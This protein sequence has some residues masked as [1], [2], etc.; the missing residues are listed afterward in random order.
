V[1]LGCLAS[2]QSAAAAAP[3]TTIATG[4][5]DLALTNDNTPTF[6]FS[7]DQAGVTFTCSVESSEVPTATYTC[8]SPFTAP[9]L[10]DGG[11]VVRIAAK[12][13]G[14]EVETP[15]AS[16]SFTVD[17]TPP[18]T[19]ITAGPADGETIDTD[20]PEFGWAASE[21][22]STFACTAD[23]IALTSCDLAFVTGA[24]AGRHSYSVA[25]TDAAGNTDPTPATRTF[26]ISFSG[27][28]PT[29]ARCQVDG[30]VVVGTN[31]ADTRV[32]TAGTDV[33]FGLA[34]N[35][36]LSAAGGRDCLA[37]QSGTGDDLLSGGAGND[38]LIGDAGRDELRGGAGN[39]SITGSAGLDV[40][41]GDAG[42]DR[43]TDASGRDS[44]SG[45]PG[46]DRIDARDNTVFGRRARDIVGCGSGRFDIAI[47]DRG[48]RVN[49]DCERV[50]R[51]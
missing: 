7:A 35:D 19:T 41:V 21:P 45:G 27:A 6:E 46:N 25:A 51:H 28:T 44:F 2:A 20:A 22:G 29:I 34:G 8:T 30:N 43:L 3:K 48:D 47:V 5:A 24:S 31:G 23:G 40:L 32:G 16:R 50:S 11:H 4:P 15:G 38:R 39:D 10:A 36:V 9:P 18:E 12:N 37:G 13:A 26:T 14:A 49:H 42:A 1:S 33:M 17:T